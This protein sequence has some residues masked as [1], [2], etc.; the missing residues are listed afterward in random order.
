MLTDM[1]KVLIKIGTKILTTPENKL[2]LNNLRRLVNDVSDLIFNYDMQCILVSSGSIICGSE[3]L[4]ITPY[5]IPEQ[6][7]SAS[8]GQLLLMKEYNH[9]FSHNMLKS[10]QILLTK[11]F[12]DDIEKKN[13]V[14]NTISK[15]LDFNIVP[16]INENDSVATDEI[17][18]GDNDILASMVATLMDIDLFVILSDIDGIYDQNPNSFSNAKLL[19]QINNITNEDIEK[20]SDSHDIRGKGGL[21]SKLMAAKLCM[22][23]GIDTIIANGRSTTKLSDTIK[24]K[25]NCTWVKAN[26]GNSL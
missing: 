2:D 3:A 22:E 18:F 11:D 10:G 26:N 23:N 5:S 19:K 21:K 13:N 9:F 1:K 8:I 20:A 15:L 12:I 17:K 14:K 16:I 7:A 24:S 25:E 4:C 6:Q